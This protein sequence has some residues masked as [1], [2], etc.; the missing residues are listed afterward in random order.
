[1]YLGPLRVVIISGGHFISLYRL[2][3]VSQGHFLVATST[4]RLAK[5]SITLM[6]FL[7]T[8]Y[9]LVDVLKVALIS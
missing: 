6:T 2:I 5:G 7:S 9:S 8:Y 3:V 4:R 1:M